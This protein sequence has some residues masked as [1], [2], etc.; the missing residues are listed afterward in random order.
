MAGNTDKIVY[1]A[2]HQVA[3]ITA[4]TLQVSHRDQG[5]VQHDVQVL[6]I[7]EA[8]V[9]LGDYSHYMLKEI[10]EQPQSLQNAMR[11]RLNK[12]RQSVV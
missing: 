4:D 6:P 1:L 11:G 12:D 10:F 2:D 5:L 7:S 3:T 9:S 8:D